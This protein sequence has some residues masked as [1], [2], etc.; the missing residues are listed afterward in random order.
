MRF[1]VLYNSRILGV[2]VGCA[3]ETPMKK[4]PPYKFVLRLHPDL[5]DQVKEAARHYRRSINSEIVARL[6][7][8]FSAL[9]PDEGEASIEPPLHCHIEQL[10][11]NRLNDTE[12]NLIRHFRRLGPK[13]QEALLN[14]LT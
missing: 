7:Q 11:R 10:F 14:L 6:E 9:P 13:R 8:S 4:P 12:M 5:R 2:P 3:S 1:L